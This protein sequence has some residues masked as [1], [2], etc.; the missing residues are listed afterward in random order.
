MGPMDDCTKHGRLLFRHITPPDRKAAYYSSQL[1]IQH[2]PEGVQYHVRGI[3]GGDQI[4]H[5][6]AKAAYTTSHATIRILLNAVVSEDVMFFTAGIKDF[7]LGTPLDRSAY[8]RILLKH[9]PLD[10]QAR[11]NM[12]QFVHHDHILMKINTSIYGLGKP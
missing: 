1:K 5:L 12:A 7:Y 6:G 10:I 4:L 2:K 9:L 11:Y 3:I 8:M